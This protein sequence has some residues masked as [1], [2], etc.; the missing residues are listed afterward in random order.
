MGYV[1][2]PQ[3][4]VDPLPARWEYRILTIDTR[5]AELLNDQAL[6]EYGSDG[7][8]LAGILQHPQL[9]HI[10]YYFVRPTGGRG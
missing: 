10:Q 4:Y 8:L 6:A 1:P 9:R 2:A 3:I 5:E 7:W